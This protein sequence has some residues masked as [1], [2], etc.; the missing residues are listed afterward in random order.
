MR[1]STRDPELLS[2]EDK[3]LFR[4][5]FDNAPIGKS[6]TAPDG[7]LIRVNR[8][9]GEMLG[10]SL[11]EM[12]SIS[13][14]EITHPDDLAESK[15]CVRCLLAGERDR[16]VME[17][18]YLHKDGRPIWTHVT[19]SLQR[20]DANRPLYFL[21]HI[22]DIDG[23]RRS[24][25]NLHRHEQIVSASADMM[26]FLDDQYTYR[27]VNPAYV[28]AFNKEAADMIG[29]TVAEVFGEEFFEEVIKPHADQCLAGE[30]V[31][32][33]AWFEF[34]AYE[35]QYMDVAYAPT[36][37]AGTRITGFTVNARDMSDQK[38]AEDALRDANDTL[39]Q[40]VLDRTEELSRSKYLLEETG[41]LARVG[42]WEI[43]LLKNEVTW[44]DVVRQIHE[45]E[46]GFQPQLDTA[47]NFYAPEA[48]PVI[49]EAVRCAIEEGKP[50]DVELQLITAKERR[51]WVRAV[52][53]PVRKDGKIEKVRGVFQ[54]IDE[55][56]LADIELR[57]HRDNLELL[58]EARTKALEEAVSSLELSNHEL[59]Q[60]AYV[61]SHDLQEPLRMVASF[62]QL[63]SERYKGQLDE[64]ADSYIGFAV[65]GARRMQGLINNLLAYSRVGS[66]AKPIERVE[67]SEVVAEALLG[68]Q[69][70]IEE[71]HADIR[72]GPL[73]AVLADRFQFGQVVQNLI[74][75]AVK[76][77]GDH[78]PVVEV[79]AQREGLQWVFEVKDNGIGI[80][81]EYFERIFVIFQRLHEREAYPGTGM[82]LA[83]VKKIIER[84]GGRIWVESEPGL[85]SRFL[86]TL[87][88]AQ[89]GRDEV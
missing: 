18:R 87:R 27:A 48:V 16:W 28:S 80:D 84:H 57:M 7:T 13:F 5:F 39:E 55:R 38:R 46:P 9:F 20:D 79:S 65:D 30:S 62:T 32:Y 58:V 8:A 51:L 12:Q 83:I 24:E 29:F 45:V 81:P 56:K 36:H 52:G 35:P 26:A 25:A 54:D 68:L 33:Q 22:L 14:S 64:K 49:S 63:L 69:Q 59:E 31:R 61:A 89:E 44:T 86:F 15:E 3:A 67:S 37:G 1:G 71:N 40:R 47:I 77:C 21:T 82:G 53:G 23:R 43:D 60:F 4:A 6:A 73:P 70:L 2:V 19:T 66:R 78:T 11:E 75:N 85:G 50:F 41:R 10:Y 76:F 42:G 72:V 88:D 74:G 34:P 17:K